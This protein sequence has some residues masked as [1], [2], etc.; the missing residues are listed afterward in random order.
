MFDVS[1]IIE[2]LVS[3]GAIVDVS[4]VVLVESVVLEFEPLLHAAKAPIAKTI[5]NFFIVCV[6][7]Y[8]IFD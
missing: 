6:F 4:V 7:C 2:L 8:V 1:V 3:A 5:N